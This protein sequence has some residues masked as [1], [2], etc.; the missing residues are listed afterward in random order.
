MTGGAHEERNATDAAGIERRRPLIALA[1]LLMAVEPLGLAFYASSILTR[2]VD[3]GTWAILLLVIRLAI[4][5]IGVGA[6]LA[7]WYARP[8]DIRFA[9]VAIALTVLGVLLTFLAPVFPHNRP[10][11]TTTPLLAALLVYYGAWFVYLTRLGARP[12]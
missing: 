4:T 9:R 12:T 11:G 2:V 3:R 7:L 1:L 10:P 5:G 6:G 8:G